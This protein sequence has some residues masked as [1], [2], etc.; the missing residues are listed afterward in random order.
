M[1]DLRSD[2]ITKPTP[3]MLEAMQKASVGD[4]VYGEDPTVH[5]LETMVADLFSMESALFCPSGT[6][7]NQIAIKCHTNPGDE[8]I[9]DKLSHIYQYEGGGIAFNSGC[10]VKLIDGSFGKINASQVE[11]HLNPSDIH[12]S[13]TA[14]VS[15]ENTSN[16]GGG[17]CYELKD[18]QDIKEICHKNN[19]GFHLD[20]ARLWNAMVAKNQPASAFGQIFDSVSVCISK[21]LGAPVG[22]LLIGNHSFIHQARRYRKVFG[23]GMRQAGYLAAAGIFAI[24]H[25]LPKL[26]EDHQ[27]AFLIAQALKKKKFVTEIF[28]VETNIIIF[29]VNGLYDAPG[30]C[31]F[32]K[33]H[34]ILCTSISS[35]QI[36]MVTHLDITKKMVEKII[37]I[38]EKA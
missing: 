38:I 28:P 26:A 9:C 27:H 24:K 25:H 29:E 17:S 10:Q 6:M 15:V 36:R 16:R 12:K 5:E 2:T 3:D 35:H 23:G 34:D 21:G 7:A 18:L 1:I 31:R 4:D 11:N 22:S 8:V 13:N 37:Q 30:F 32:L 19:I 14:L 33:G 20:G